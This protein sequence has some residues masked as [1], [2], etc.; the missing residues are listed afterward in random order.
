MTWEKERLSDQL[1]MHNKEI[2]WLLTENNDMA[3]QIKEA[4]E[5]IS[6]HENGF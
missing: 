1:S 4:M 3:F 2:K 5:I 6:W